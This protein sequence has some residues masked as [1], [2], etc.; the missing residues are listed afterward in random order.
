MMTKRTFCH[1]LNV[2]CLLPASRVISLARAMQCAAVSCH[3][4]DC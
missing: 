4:R 3:F 1:Q 2:A